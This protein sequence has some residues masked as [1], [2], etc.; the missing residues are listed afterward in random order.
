MLND[1]TVFDTDVLSYPQIVPIG[2]Y[3]PRIIEWWSLKC[4]TTTG[5]HVEEN[6]CFSPL[7][8]LREGT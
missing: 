2:L 7:R 3:F 4:R 5:L 1:S 8:F 6:W